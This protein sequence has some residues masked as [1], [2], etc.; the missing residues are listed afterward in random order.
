MTRVYAIQIN[1]CGECPHV[2]N[3]Y[4]SPS[5]T[6]H[7]TPLHNTWWCTKAPDRY[8]NTVEPKGEPPEWCPLPPTGHFGDANKMV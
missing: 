1:C 6:I 8:R 3:S 7:S 2:T 5:T 4:R